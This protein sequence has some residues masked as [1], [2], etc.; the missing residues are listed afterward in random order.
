M[1]E[2]EILLFAGDLNGHIGEDR[3]GFKEVIMGAHG[4][5]VRN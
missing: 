2:S 5:G 3:G 1:A 4:F